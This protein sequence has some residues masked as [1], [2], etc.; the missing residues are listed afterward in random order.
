MAPVS[1]LLAFTALVTVLIAIPGPSV[2]FTVS[3]ALA[4]GRRSALFTVAGNEIGEYA[5]VIGVAFGVGALVERSAEI[6][7]IVKWAGAAYLVYLGVQAIRHR[8]SVSGAL[9]ARAAPPKTLQAIRQGFV[10]GATNPKTIVIF[11]VILPE[12]TVRGP[13]HLPVQGQLLILGALFTA[14][15]LILD[16]G[17]AVVAGTARQ[18]LARSPRRL[19]LIGGT[20][21]LVM[22]GLGISVAATGRSD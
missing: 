21:G 10:V 12:F 13:G 3:R 16:S 18:W 1:H 22:I 20:S 9:A 5:Q 15:A 11:A 8:R 7:A 19:A 2:L 14:I 6:F 4:A 17:W